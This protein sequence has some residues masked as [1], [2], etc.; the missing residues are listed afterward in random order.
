MK[1]IIKLFV[2]TFMITILSCKNDKSV[3]QTNVEN[4]SETEVTI[5][6]TH[7]KTYTGAEI[8]DWLPN[9]ILEFVKADVELGTEELHQIKTHYQY[10]SGYEKY[11][12]LEITNGQSGKDLS[13]Q[14]K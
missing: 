7:F 6:N 1:N 11:L 13:H 4:P 8:N 14:I 12:E 9:T 5:N 2:L 3:S 10:Q